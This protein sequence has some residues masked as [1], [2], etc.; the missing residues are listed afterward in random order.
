ML[1]FVSN[2]KSRCAP[3]PSPPMIWK[4][5]A[6]ANLCSFIVDRKNEKVKKR[7]AL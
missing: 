6:T 5:D 3:N 4:V 2:T 7:K 1:C